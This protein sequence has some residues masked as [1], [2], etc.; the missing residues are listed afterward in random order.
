MKAKR[1]FRE[2][3]K[4]SENSFFV[5]S[6]SVTLRDALKETARQSDICIL[7]SFGNFIPILLE[8]LSRL[9][10]AIQLK[11]W[12]GNEKIPLW[13]TFSNIFGEHSKSWHQVY[14][15][16]VI[17]LLL[18]G[19]ITGI[20]MYLVEQFGPTPD[21]RYVCSKSHLHLTTYL[22]FCFRCYADTFQT[23]IQA[24]GAGAGIF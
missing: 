10:W 13:E 23:N 24:C 20:K 2:D 3:L 16:M 21:P 5:M 19:A 7:L 4:V 22:I 14:V 6:I 12:V 9:N 15:A 17:I 1:Q 18:A 8:S 11:Q